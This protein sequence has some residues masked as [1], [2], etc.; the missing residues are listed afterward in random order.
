MQIKQNAENV[1][2]L[3][4]QANIKPDRVFNAHQSGFNCELTGN[5]S[6][7]M[8]NS[9]TVMKLFQSKNAGSPSSTMLPTISMSGILQRKVLVTFQETEAKFDPRVK[10]TM[11][12]LSNLVL[13]ASSSGMINKNDYKKYISEIFSPMAKNNN[14]N[15]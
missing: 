6:L 11:L 1:K 12:R 13:D 7:S 2:E 4:K 14:V 3:I 9:K 5:R 15:L 10:N 8:K